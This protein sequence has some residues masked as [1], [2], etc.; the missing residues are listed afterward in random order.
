M[1]L[2]DRLRRAGFAST[3]FHYSSM[4]ATLASAAAALAERLRGLGAAAHVVAHSLGGIVALEAFATAPD[5]PAGRAVLLGSPVQGSRAAQSIAA[6]SFGP[7]IL[8]PL[9]VAE[10]AQPRARRWVGTREIGVISGSRSAGLGR[11]CA[12]LPQPNDGT[13]CVSET[14]LPGA[15]AQLVLDVSHTGMLFSGQVADAVVRF[16]ETGRF[17]SSAE[18]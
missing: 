1:L 4:Q 5:L 2:R 18:G 13:I 7:Q 6:W 8:G 17:A 16:L 10:I 14:L 11:F 9:A 12:D 3:V 15:S